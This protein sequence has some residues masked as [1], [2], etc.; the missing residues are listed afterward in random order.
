LPFTVTGMAITSIPV[1]CIV[2]GLGLWI[3]LAYGLTRLIHA[4]RAGKPLF[5]ERHR[6][7]VRS[8]RSPFIQPG[9]LYQCQ[10]NRRR[11]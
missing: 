5:Y 3:G 6:K 10:I 2:P 4:Q 11:L 9:V 7:A 1:L 8:F